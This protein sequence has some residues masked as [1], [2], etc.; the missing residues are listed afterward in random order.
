MQELF[1]KTGKTI[2]A[3]KQCVNIE[4]CSTSEISGEV[5]QEKDSGQ[6]KRQEID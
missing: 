6:I 5:Q 2:Y 3:T 1:C 4:D